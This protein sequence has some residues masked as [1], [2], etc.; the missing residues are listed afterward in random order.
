MVEKLT[1]FKKIKN[2]KIK[3]SL[4]LLGESEC[5]G[6]QFFDSLLSQHSQLG[7]LWLSTPHCA[8]LA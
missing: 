4:A 7:H 3:T 8:A 6:N 2:K 5:L 1:C